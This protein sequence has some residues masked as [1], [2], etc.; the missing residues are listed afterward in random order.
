M[1]I[2]RMIGQ[3]QIARRIA[4]EIEQQHPN[5]RHLFPDTSFL[6]FGPSD[7][8]GIKPRPARDK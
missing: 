8:I 7:Y 2:E 4:E 1:T 3:N 6:L 5:S